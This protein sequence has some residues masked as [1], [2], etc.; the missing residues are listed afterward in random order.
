MSTF[1][2]N[3]TTSCTYNGQQVDEIILDGTQIWLG[4]LPPAFY[5]P[6]GTIYDPLTDT[7][8]GAHPNNAYPAIY[9]TNDGM[10]A[11]PIVIDQGS[12]YGQSIQ[13][14]TT[15]EG[16][17]VGSTPIYKINSTNT[18]F[19]PQSSQVVTQVQPNQYGPI[20]NRLTLHTDSTSLYIERYFQGASTFTV[21]HRI[22][23]DFNGPFPTKGTL[24]NVD[25][26]QAEYPQ[27]IP[28][29]NEETYPVYL[30][31]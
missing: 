2:L 28:A 15:I 18:G 24:V 5:G 8:F 23:Y 9:F 16:V 3:S 22:D 12:G 19:V 30:S 6:A 25:T 11:Y 27:T 1:D 26:S 31:T 29:Y 10:E 20:T 14:Q 21:W 17:A 4:S 13:N 7:A